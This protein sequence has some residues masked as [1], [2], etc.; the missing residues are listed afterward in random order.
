[1]HG[2]RYT[3]EQLAVIRWENPHIEYTYPSRR[4]KWYLSYSVFYFCLKQEFAIRILKE[5]GKKFEVEI[6][7]Q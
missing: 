4:K 3:Y 2:V 5:E 1:M 7:L 6:I